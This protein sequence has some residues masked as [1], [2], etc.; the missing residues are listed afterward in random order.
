MPM[1][2]PAPSA[3]HVLPQRSRPPQEKRTAWP[4]QFWRDAEPSHLVAR[5]DR[6]RDPGSALN[7]ALAFPEAGLL[8]MPLS[9]VRRHRGLHMAPPLDTTT[10]PWHASPA[11]YTARRPLVA[12]GGGMAF[13]V[14]CK[15]CGATIFPSI[16]AV[17]PAAVAELVA[18]ARSCPR[19]GRDKPLLDPERLG[20]I[21][22]FYDIRSTRT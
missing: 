20:T 19:A 4:G 15:G 22:P 21:L 8:P 17:D 10:G 16:D 18:H 3:R 2:R 9:L 7:V 13:R 6:R 5:S 12:K 1:M 14:T 11:A